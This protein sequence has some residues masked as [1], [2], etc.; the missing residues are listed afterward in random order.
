MPMLKKHEPIPTPLRQVRSGLITPQGVI[1]KVDRCAPEHGGGLL[2]WFPNAEHGE[3][4]EPDAAVPVFGYVESKTLD[5]FRHA[6]TRRTG[7]NYFN[8]I[9]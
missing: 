8:G 9:R 1:L 2:L 7:I 5:R 4:I 6:S 3:H